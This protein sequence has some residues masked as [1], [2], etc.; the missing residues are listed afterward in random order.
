[1][2]RI[3]EENPISELWR[4]NDQE[5]LR[6]LLTAGSEDESDQTSIL[7]HL[8]SLQSLSNA[9]TSASQAGI[10]LAKVGIGLTIASLILVLV[11]S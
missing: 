5:R 8:R 11:Q 6:E 3:P 4:K 10:F 9:I 7:L 2:V 1:M